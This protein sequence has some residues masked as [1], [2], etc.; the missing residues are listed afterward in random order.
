MEYANLIDVILAK[1][2][3]ARETHKLL[4]LECRLE[5]YDTVCEHSGTQV[6]FNEERLAADHTSHNDTRAIRAIMTF[7]RAKMLLRHVSLE[8]IVEKGMLLA[9]ISQFSEWN[10]REDCFLKMH[11]FQTG[12]MNVEEKRFRSALWQIKY[13]EANWPGLPVVH[14]LTPNHGSI[15]ATTKKR[16]NDDQYEPY[17]K[18]S[19]YQLMLRNL[20][21]TLQ[22]YLV[23]MNDD[24]K[25]GA[26]RSLALV[27][28]QAEHNDEHMI[29]LW[30]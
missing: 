2:L 4:L 3:I 8:S 24:T 23:L 1:S 29:C 30:L 22:E 25:R 27:G 9:D 15:E 14:R 20:M 11:V 18:A 6:A 26:E 28:G 12:T 5:I 13:F 16:A 17:R 21:V 19:N 10:P 7:R